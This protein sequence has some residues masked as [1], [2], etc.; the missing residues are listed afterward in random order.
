M[1][2]PK[3]IA[4]GK[5]RVEVRTDRGRGAP[6]ISRTFPTKGEALAWA[7]S[8][9]SEVLR[10]TWQDLHGGDTQL[11]TYAEAWITRQRVAPATTD[12]YRAV[13]RRLNP[14]LGDLRLTQLRRPVLERTLAGL[15]YKGKALAP[16][17]L[18]GTHAVLAM[19]LKG[20]V[21]DGHLAVSP[22]AGVKPPSVPRRE[23]AVFDEK[24]L[25]ALLAKAGD[26]RE[27]FTVAIGTGMRQGEMFGLRRA[28]V[29]FLRRTISVEEQVV[30]GPGRPA[31]LTSTLKTPAS[32]RRL[33]VS[34][35]VVQGL[36]R[37]VEADPGVDVFFRSTRGGLW[38]RQTFNEVV[39][40]PALTRAGL[41]DVGFHALRHSYA[42]HLIAA[43]LHPRVIQ[44]R[45][46]HASIVETMGTYGHLFPD[47][48]DATRVALDSLFEAPEKRGDELGTDAAGPSTP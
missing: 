34:D 15:T 1:G 4:K 35:A 36:S 5:W 45:M 12:F 40:K 7:T 21:V 19:I 18:A 26:Y 41:P 37:L 27:L 48:D 13:W 20:A 3:Q 25:R 38:R 11:R 29:D 24:Q 32:R 39:W 22:L 30:S 9:R 17:T 16:S 42:S 46:G 14:T 28:R 43:G 47:G 31:A 44:A 33:P 8:V 23:V 6:R 10:G 2:E